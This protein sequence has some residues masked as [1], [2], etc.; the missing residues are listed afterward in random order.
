MAEIIEGS[1]AI[2]LGALDSGC[3]AYCSY[4]VTPQNEI[5][6]WFS[7]EFPAR[8]RTFRQSTSE[9]ESTFISMGFAAAGARTMTSTAGPGWGLYPEGMS[10]IVA[11]ELP[12]VVAL[13]MRGGPGQGSTRHSQMDY[14]SATRPGGQGGYKNIVLAPYSCQECYDL[15]QLAFHLT[16]KYRNPVMILSEPNVT[17][18]LELVERKSTDYGPVPDKDWALKGRGR[19]KDQRPSL[20]T[21]GHGMTPTEEYPDYR[22]YLHRLHDKFKEMESE[23]RYEEYETEDAEIILVA[24]G[25]PARTCREATKQ[26]R[27]QGI[28]VGLIRPISLWPFPVEPIRRRAG[29]GAKFLVVEDNLGDIGGLVDDVRLAASGKAEIRMVTALDRHEPGESGAIYTGKVLDKI[30]NMQG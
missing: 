13:I 4:P 2:G 25:Y 26:A 5:I 14:T 28:K 7:R 27:S 19:H 18:M 11:A 3:D 24:Y 30:K 6:E 29:T 23:I 15:T 22:S 10:H 21:S 16:E 8:G 12:L 17:R 9:I 20:I 1:I